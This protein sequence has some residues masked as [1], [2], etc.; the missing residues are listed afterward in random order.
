[1]VGRSFRHTDV[2]GVREIHRAC[3]CEGD[4]FVCRHLLTQ[5]YHLCLAIDISGIPC[6]SEVLGWGSWRW[7]VCVAMPW[8]GRGGVAASDEPL[9]KWLGVV[10]GGRV[11][12]LLRS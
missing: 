8:A 10:R 12:V 4:P 5:G 7:R 1:M 6:P 2:V 9:R 11:C 3:K